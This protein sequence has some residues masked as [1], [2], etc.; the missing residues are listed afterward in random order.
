MTA[1]AISAVLLAAGES[2]RMGAVNKLALQ[3]HGEPLLRRMAKTLTQANLSEVV[4]VLGFEHEKTREML[5]GLPLHIA[6]NPDYA[7]GQMSS[8]HCGLRALRGK[9]SAVMMCLSD[10][11]LLDTRDLNRLAARFSERPAAVLA[12]TYQGRRGN[13]IIL[14]AEQRGA[15][16]SGERNLG[17]RHFIANN[18]QLVE[19][20]EFDNDHVVFDI[21][22]PE[23]YKRLQHAT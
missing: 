1:P 10:Q 6:V 8:A 11:P 4:V 23:D 19:T 12:P 3:A 2:R 21:D 13:P 7:Q 14:A 17:C 16:L 5:D 20:Y 15:I 9:D 22:T 18:P